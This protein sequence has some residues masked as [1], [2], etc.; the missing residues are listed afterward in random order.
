VY[1]VMASS[2]LRR[3]ARTAISFVM[4]VILCRHSLMTIAETGGP[5]CCKRGSFL[6]IL[7]AL[8][9]TAD[10]F[11]VEMADGSAD[12][13]CEFSRLNKECKKTECGF[14]PA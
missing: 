12:L 9:F 11:H 8:R 6:A 7:E 5:R 10:Q 3:S 13:K 4:P 14:Y 1:S 2:I